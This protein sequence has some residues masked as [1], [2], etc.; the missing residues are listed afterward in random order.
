MPNTASACRPWPSGRAAWAEPARWRAA[1]AWARPWTL[2]SRS[3]LKQWP[4]MDKPT[5]IR[6]LLVDDH[7]IVREGLRA[8]LGDVEDFLIVGEAANGDEACKVA[9]KLQPDLVLIDLKM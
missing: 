4:S 2:Q 3:V 9:G 6:L 5:P 1:W 8:L 7:A